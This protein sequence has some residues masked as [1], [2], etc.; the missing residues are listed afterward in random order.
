MVTNKALN[1]ANVTNKEFKQTDI[2][3]G[4]TDP[5]TFAEHTGPFGAP[6]A[7]TN[8]PLNTASVTNKALS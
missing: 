7:L 4:D 1:T 2:T 3:F 5:A 6:Y 8:K